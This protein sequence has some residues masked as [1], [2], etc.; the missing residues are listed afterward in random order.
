MSDAGQPLIIKERGDIIKKRPQRERAPRVN[1]DKRLASEL[2]GKVEKY[3]KV[4]FTII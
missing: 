3:Q 1:Q 4:C 2:L